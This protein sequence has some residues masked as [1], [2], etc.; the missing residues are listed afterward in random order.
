MQMIVSEVNKSVMFETPEP[1]TFLSD[2]DQFLLFGTFQESGRVIGVTDA[3]SYT[4]TY[5]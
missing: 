2:H 5:T 3:C 4:L 1:T